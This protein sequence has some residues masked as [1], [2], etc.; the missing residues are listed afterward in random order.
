M[1]KQTALLFE[2]LGLADQVVGTGDQR[3]SGGGLM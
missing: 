3:P 2:N 1:D